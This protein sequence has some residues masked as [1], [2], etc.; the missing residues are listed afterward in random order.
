MLAR[1]GLLR[2][3]QHN[4]QQQQHEEEY[5][6]DGDQVMSE[7]QANDE[8][9]HFDSEQQQQQPTNAE[10]STTSQQQN[11]VDD[12][13]EEEVMPASKWD[14][15]RDTILGF[16]QLNQH[17]IPR[18]ILHSILSY[19]PAYPYYF[20]I[21]GV[22][23]QWMYELEEV[24][25]D[26]V[27]VLDLVF[28]GKPMYYIRENDQLVRYKP[29]ECSG[30]NF[31]LQDLKEARKIT[32][33]D[34]KHLPIYNF[35]TS[36]FKNVK[37]LRI[38]LAERNHSILNVV[39]N[40]KH[41]ERVDII[42]HNFLS[43]VS[44]WTIRCI[45]QMLPEGVKTLNIENLRMRESALVNTSVFLNNGIENFSARN[46]HINRYH[47]A[48]VP[49]EEF[50]ELMQTGLKSFE[51]TTV[52]NT[53]ETDNNYIDYV[54][55]MID[56]REFMVSTI[57]DV[58]N[59][60]YKKEIAELVIP[61]II[62]EY[63]EFGIVLDKKY[64]CNSISGSNFQRLFM[65]IP[66]SA[67]IV[68]NLKN[69]AK[70][71]ELLKLLTDIQVMKY[72]EILLNVNQPELNSN[73]NLVS[74]LITYGNNSDV[75]I[76]L[77]KF[78]FNDLGAN[79][80]VD[81]VYNYLYLCLR[82][83]LR[84]DLADFF[85]SKYPQLLYSGNEAGIISGDLEEFEIG[86][87]LIRETWHNNY[88]IVSNINFL[89]Q[90]GH[91]LKRRDKNGCNLLHQAMQFE[92]ISTCDSILNTILKTSHET[93]KELLT[94]KN[95]NGLT[96]IQLLFINC[97][98]HVM[99]DAL[100]NVQ[101]Y[102]SIFGKEILTHT[103]VNGNNL[104]HISVKRNFR[105]PWNELL[106][107]H[108]D[109]NMTNNIGQTPLFFMDNRINWWYARENVQ[110][111]ERVDLFMSH[112]AKLDVT[113]M[114]GM[115]PLTNALKRRNWRFL[116][117]ILKNENIDISMLLGTRSVDNFNA[118]HF[119]LNAMGYTLGHVR[120]K[121]RKQKVFT[122]GDYPL[123]KKC[124]DKCLQLYP[125]MLYERSSETATEK[126]ADIC[127]PTTT[128][129]DREETESIGKELYGVSPLQIL[130]EC[131]NSPLMLSE[132]NI[133][134]S[135]IAEK[136]VYKTKDDTEPAPIGVVFVARDA[137][138]D[139]LLFDKMMA[140]TKNAFLRDETHEDKPNLLH[141]AAESDIDM[142]KSVLKHWKRV[143]KKKADLQKQ[144]NIPLK[145][146]GKGQLIVPVNLAAAAGNTAVFDLLWPY[147]KSIADKI[148]SP[149]DS[150]I[151]FGQYQC[152]ADLVQVYN[153]MPT[154]K[155]QFIYILKNTTVA[156]A[157]DIL[158]NLEQSI[159]SPSWFD[160]FTAKPASTNI[161]SSNENEEQQIVSNNYSLLQYLMRRCSV[162]ILDWFFTQF[163]NH[164]NIQQ[165]ALQS[166][167]ETKESLLHLLFN[168]EN[169]K[170]R[171]I[172]RDK[173]QI[174]TAFIQIFSTVPTIT[175]PARTRT[176]TSKNSS[177]NTPVID[178][179]KVEQLLN[180]QDEN[181]NTCL[182]L[183]MKS[184]MQQVLPEIIQYGA[185]V[186]IINNEGQ[187]AMDMA[188]DEIMEEKLQT[189][190]DIRSGKVKRKVQTVSNEDSDNDDEEY[191]QPKKRTRR[192][193]RK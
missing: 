122:D 6:E 115:N 163:R 136:P 112:G 121:N 164:P 140:V 22:N 4:S 86:H 2:N 180:K 8:K 154:S 108:I 109:P 36:V 66:D 172:Q 5:E 34:Y 145:K 44:E 67:I 11:V 29:I 23:K 133:S 170:D 128:S 17:D 89:I 137:S 27:E 123:I 14:K 93:A 25:Y 95:E 49:M 1:A 80:K 94:Q 70:S 98:D 189:Q 7:E 83:S 24:M 96:P 186:T 9:K 57:N 118:L 55:Q 116:T 77:V 120:S 179:S 41:L 69:A 171:S 149:I 88:N 139:S 156:N 113:D 168:S 76:S 3:S 97:R 91:D 160:L 182:H 84:S 71:E 21:R 183:V 147:N 158:I 110:A 181:G 165:I 65:T 166:D 151:E 79:Y 155:E 119:L 178:K 78:L 81:G 104:L 32:H 161:A 54:K 193:T 174:F 58:T 72:P 74:N 42:G 188:L 40:W 191:E 30:R 111:D 15:Q 146:N 87:T 127:K 52:S 37:H 143:H 126:T 50:T 192:S 131:S 12:S 63:E 138:V 31:P 153:I 105:N 19:I 60:M 68:S 159:P 33:I 169:Q 62:R 162:L 144:I 141:Y 45:S 43:D 124:V 26:N 18:E 184:G 167:P 142:C 35:L 102:V 129:Y 39:S 130:L 53:D 85:I 103:D 59:Y 75:Q 16:F 114:N 10:T 64:S 107:L 56:R 106:L 90:H 175:S 101:R 173:T 47:Y 157:T 148:E 13:T 61:A 125:E 46:I 38:S 48:S 20:T 132:C 100:N 117:A 185:D 134:L 176:R 82:Y 152:A 150:A 190:L 187:T 28:Y 99:Q 177:S 51:I 135:D 92:Q 73:H